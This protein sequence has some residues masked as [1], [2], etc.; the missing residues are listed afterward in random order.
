MEKREILKRLDHT[1]LKQ[2][3]TW[4]QV[5][6]LCEEGM[7]YEVASVC[8]PPC[9]VKK[10]KD[11]VKERLK[12]CTVIGFPNGNMTTAA[13]V[14]ETE[15]AVKNGADEIDMV[16][17]LGMV[18]EQNYEGVLAEIQEIKKACHGKLLKV[19]IE[20]CL[21][22]EEE[23]MKLCQVVSKSGADYIKTSTG[24]STGGATFG[25]VEL[26]RKHVEKGIKVKAAGGIA[27]VEDAEKFIALGADR[28]GTSRLISLLEKK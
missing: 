21:L 12:I 24:F 4:E 8:I 20:T 22:T 7:E 19:I 10:A 5:Q 28:L 16:I 27:S 26:M 11:Y 18:K 13:K 15:D 3:A 25:D 9:Y 6:A 23:K 1:L 17:N 2:T 14:F